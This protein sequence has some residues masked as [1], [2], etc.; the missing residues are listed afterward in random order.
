MGSK[1]ESKSSSPVQFGV[2]F[3]L[4]RGK[5]RNA[6]PTHEFGERNAGMASIDLSMQM[7]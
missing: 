4:N 2:R 5:S 7:M 3:D 6:A 1:S